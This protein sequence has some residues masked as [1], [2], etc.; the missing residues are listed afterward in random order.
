MCCINKK[1]DAAFGWETL[2]ERRVVCEKQSTLEN[3]FRPLQSLFL[4]FASS[5][6]STSLLALII[7]AAFGFHPHLKRCPARLPPLVH[8]CPFISIHTLRCLLY[9]AEEI[10]VGKRRGA[11][12]IY[13]L[14]WRSQ[15]VHSGRSSVGR[16]ELMAA[17]V[18]ACRHHPPLPAHWHFHITKIYVNLIFF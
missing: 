14:L 9:V 7:T 17:R 4:S 15:Y 6:F 3:G 2:E 11:V 12:I 16:G 5:S 18:S 8:L 10:I 1:L 13:P